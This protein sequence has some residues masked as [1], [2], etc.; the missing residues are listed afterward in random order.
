MDRTIGLRSIAACAGNHMLITA[1]GYNL[2]AAR[3]MWLYDFWDAQNRKEAMKFAPTPSRIHDGA[4]FRMF[5]LELG[6]AGRYW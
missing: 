6:K 1:L 5:H 4:S 3:P 2:C